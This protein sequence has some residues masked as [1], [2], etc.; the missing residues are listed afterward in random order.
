M[1]VTPSPRIL[2]MLGEIEIAEW[3]CLAELIDNSVDELNQRNE[4]VTLTAQEVNELSCIEILL[5]TEKADRA[6]AEIE[7]RD[8]G[9]GMTQEQLQKAVKAGWS[10]NDPF[11][12]LGLF[13][14]GFN[15]ATARLG[16]VTEILTTQA[17]ESEWRGVRIDLDE[18]GEDFE[19][20]DIREPKDDPSSH[21]TKVKVSRLDPDR[22]KYLTSR[23]EV[24]RAK[25]G[26][27]YSWLIE[28]TPI[29]IRMNGRLVTP[30]RHCVWHESRYVL[31]GR[32]RQQEQIPAVIKIDRHL[33][34]AEACLDC[35]HWQGIGK[36]ECERCQG[37]NIRIRERR[38]HG[39][40]G[41]Q[42][43][44]DS[45][46]YGIDYIRN[47][48][49]ILMND[50]SVFEF[51]DPNDPLT[52]HIE[53]PI[54]LPANM[55]RIVGEIHLDH[56]PVDY[57]KDRFET[58]SR[59]W[60]SAI[61][62]LRGEGPLRPKKF[63][64]L[65]FDQ[66]DSPIGKLFRG[67]QR[68]DPGRKC[69]IPGDGRSAIHKSAADWG[70]K[71][72]RGDADYQTDEK[73][74]EAVVYH[75]EQ[76]A[77]K[78][79][80]DPSSVGEVDNTAILRAL[81]V[82]ETGTSTTTSEET[83]PTDGGSNGGDVLGR[84]LTV[85]EQVDALLKKA[86]PD[87][88]LTRE[89]RINV[90]SD[91]LDIKAWSVPG[92]L[93]V[94]RETER[95]TPV[96]LY[97]TGGGSAHLFFDANH[98]TFKRHGSELLDLVLAEVAYFMGTRKEVFSSWKLSQLIAELRSDTFKDANVDFPT[99]QEAARSVLNSVRAK[100]VDGVA[101]D[102]LRAWGLLTEAEIDR[103][104]KHYS[105]MGELPSSETSDFIED[106]PA[107]YLVRLLQEWPE[108][109]TDGHVFEDRY[110]PLTSTDAK[111]MVKADLVSLML[112][113]ATVASEEREIASLNQLKRT[114]LSLEM[115]EQRMTKG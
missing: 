82:A 70:L 77:K 79:E 62:F 35:G 99:V 50:K 7:V 109:F 111:Q 72:S 34:D 36:N 52:R 9:R 97:P 16:R 30:R 31:A 98:E 19:V 18:I 100:L 46:H 51:V 6:D 13:G 15:V 61:M 76:A 106:V 96:L 114:R 64:S 40:V 74:W 102:P 47:G 85:A 88:S 103:L 1:Q 21:G 33:P 68:N 29:T 55:G 80:P 56:V 59:D 23:R 89:Y 38:I 48:R 20:P 87:P 25:L 113:C 66:N 10:G 22:F 49:K 93:V 95:P 69:L 2:S 39:W 110:A 67:Y 75:D 45:D 37:T 54:E 71:F 73:W 91:H 27:V 104:Q 44:L 43:Y 14:M 3:Q 63:A 60:I 4:G 26:Q 24:I 84:P 92:P 42:R 12:R 78:N 90:I 83:A 32:G 108:V 11:D 81:G 112:D 5:P 58:S 17:G 8:R 105:S 94:G 86:K 107:M 28:T 41:I 101:E 53:Y 115:L 57:K 65:G